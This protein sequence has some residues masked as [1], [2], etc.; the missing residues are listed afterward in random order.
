MLDILLNNVLGGVSLFKKQ[1]DYAKATFDTLIGANTE[2]S[3]N[4]ISKGIIRIDGKVTGNVSIQGDIF[5][6]ENAF[7][8]GDVNATNV[9]VAGLIEGN[10]SSSGTLKLIS[11][12]KLIGDI[13]V[14]SFVCEEG[15]IFQGRCQ[16]LDE[17]SEKTYLGKKKDFKKSSAIVKD[18]E[19]ED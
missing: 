5:V 8:K 1:T 15:S 3:G 10:I 2:I 13:Q 7:I 12:S 11:S 14:K 18:N 17:P 19:K 4:V 9:H 6:G 16:M